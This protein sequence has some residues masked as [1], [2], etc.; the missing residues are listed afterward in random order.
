MLLKSVSPAIPTQNAALIDGILTGWVF[1]GRRCVGCCCE[2]LF[3]EADSFLWHTTPAIGTTCVMTVVCSLDVTEQKGDSGAQRSLALSSE[4]RSQA[5][6]KDV[7]GW[8][9]TASVMADLRR[10]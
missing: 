6:L 8:T 7:Q 5:L 4:E 1:I 10:F 9:A 2:T 3:G